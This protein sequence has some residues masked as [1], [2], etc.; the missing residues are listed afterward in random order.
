QAHVP[1]AART[2]ARAGGDDDGGLFEDSCRERGRIH[3]LRILDPDV[4]RSLRG[5]RAE[6]GLGERSEREIATALIDRPRALDA[7]LISGERGDPGFLYG[8]EDA[9]VDVRL[10]LAE[11]GDQLFVAD[12]EAD[13]PA[14]HV[15]GL[16]KRVELDADVAR[17]VDLEERQRLLAV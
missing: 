17:A 9:G 7:A 15:V 1:F 10:H 3:T 8:L 14:R 6:A 11:A 2:E 13:P 5:D 16:R 12:R 4:E